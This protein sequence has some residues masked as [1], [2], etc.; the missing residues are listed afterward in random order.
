VVE[1]LILKASKEAGIKRREV[2]DQE[3]LERCI[4]AL[5]NEGAEILE[6]GIAL[7]ASD[8]DIVYVYGYGFP[9][10][11]G[12]PMFHA[13]TV[14]LDKVHEAVQRYHSAHGELWKPAPLLAKLAA[15]GKK[16]NN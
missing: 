5:V 14:G 4:Y 8:I 15:E 12:G 16:F 2:S 10:F 3:I 11:R 7:R 1:S 6:E 9:R 13:D